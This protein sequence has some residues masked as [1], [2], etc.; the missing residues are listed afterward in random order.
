[1]L[2]LIQC[3]LW[4]LIQTWKV[5]FL[6]PISDVCV[7]FHP[8]YIMHYFFTVAVWFLVMELLILCCVAVMTFF[9]F[10]CCSAKY[11]IFFLEYTVLVLIMLY[12]RFMYFRFP[13]F[14]YQ[15]KKLNSNK[16]IRKWRGSFYSYFMCMF[17]SRMGIKRL[18]PAKEI[19]RVF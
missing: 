2:Y 18:I 9:E 4:I 10:P 6:R 13:S 14:V 3:F 11:F 15:Q 7:C 12:T 8:V 17:I 1:M 16:Q 19:Q 5:F